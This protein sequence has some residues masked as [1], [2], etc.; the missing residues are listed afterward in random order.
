MIYD[1]TS[2]AS[3]TWHVSKVHVVA[4]VYDFL[5]CIVL[6]CMHRPC[7]VHSFHRW[8]TLMLLPVGGYYEWSSCK[9]F[10]ASLHVDV[11]FHFSGS[12][13]GVEL[14]GY[15]V[16]LT[17][18]KTATLFS[19]VSPFYILYGSDIE[20]ETS[21]MR[22]SWT[23]KEGAYSCSADRARQHVWRPGEVKA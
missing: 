23:C 10:T 8:W 16:H 15:V 2:L 3:L 1:L 22:R 17:F 4:V 6:N 7:C 9:P 19:K 20:A 14:L 21:Q 18:L 5:L 11:Y 12:F 13:L